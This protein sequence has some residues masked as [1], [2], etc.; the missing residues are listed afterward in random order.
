MR[1]QT[2]EIYKNRAPHRPPISETQQQL[3]GE[4]YRRPRRKDPPSHPQISPTPK[5]PRAKRIEQNNNNKGEAK[6]PSH[7]NDE[8]RRPPERA[9]ADLNFLNGG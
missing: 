8:E 4:A 3:T 1:N 5:N 6:E 9:N 2:S 7:G